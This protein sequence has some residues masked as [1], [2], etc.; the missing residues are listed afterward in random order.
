MDNAPRAQPFFLDTEGGQRFCLFHPPEGAC[1]GAVLYVHPFADEMN[2]ARRMAAVQAR[3]L[4][5]HGYG[6]L[7]LDLHGCGDSA[8]EFH[9]ARWAGWK[10]DLAAGCAWLAGRLDAPVTPPLT[11]WGLRLGALLALDFAHD[12]AQAGSAPSAPI[13][14]L[15]LWQP[16]QSGSAFLTQ[17][18]RLLSA[19]AMLAEGAGSASTPAA[20][21]AASTAALRASLL[22]GTMLEVA[23]YELA[24][25]LAAAI[26]QVELAAL[27][28]ACPVHWFET[29]SA[30]ER[31][32]T[33]ALERLAKGWREQGVAL[34]LHKV[35][36]APFWSTQ[37]IAEAPALLA[38][39]TAVFAPQSTAHDHAFSRASA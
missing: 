15:V 7:Q 13:S 20:G 3:A 2:K 24:P 21:P 14:Q 39:T 29:V 34:A 27:A 10:A 18:L 19:N 11:L 9:E 37:E 33:P 8:G 5:A 6:V 4:A 36:G 23:G 16:V 1:R 30:P 35:A 12:C 31:P 38:A 26:D 17:F 25:E 28:P 22:G 32:L